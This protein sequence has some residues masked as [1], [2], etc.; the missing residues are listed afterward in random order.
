MAIG[1]DIS[2]QLDISQR[3]LGHELMDEPGLDPREHAVA[4]RALSRLNWISN[5]AGILWRPIRELA[6]TPGHGPIRLLDIA[7]GS[8]DVPV[9]L[10]RRAARAGV[11]LEIEGCDLS[12]RAL[13]IARRRA[14]GAGV[15]ARFFRLDAVEDALPGEYDVVTSS[16]FMHH[17]RE[18]Q[19]PALLYKMRC[20][21]RRMVL[22]NDLRRTQPGL[23]AAYLASRLCCRSHVVRVDAMLS[24]RA[25]FTTPEF[26]ALAAEAGL[27]GATVQPRWPMR[28]LLTWRRA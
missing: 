5:S 21:A 11:R 7:T 10:A 6:A 26:E 25:A 9:A 16:L 12:E 17:L 3:V 22:V 13:E 24:V 20:G 1:L 27:D 8:G 19:I 14:A 15:G 4:L 18:D 28:F 2:R 23:V